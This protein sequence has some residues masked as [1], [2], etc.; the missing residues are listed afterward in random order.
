MYEKEAVKEGCEEV[1]FIDTGGR[2]IF[3]S[4]QRG[5]CAARGSGRYYFVRLP[6]HCHGVHIYFGIG[7]GRTFFYKIRAGTFLLIILT[8][9]TNA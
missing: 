5:E 1:S 8:F 9:K 4:G 7:A 3:L 6:D 2:D